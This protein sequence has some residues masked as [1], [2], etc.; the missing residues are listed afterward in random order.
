MWLV[1]DN[2]RIDTFNRS[3]VMLSTRI[4]RYDI[5]KRTVWIKGEKKSFDL[6]VNAIPPDDLFERCY[7]ELKFIGRSFYKLVSRPSTSSRSMS[8][9]STTPTT[10]PSPGWWSARNLPTTSRR[11]RWWGW[12]FPR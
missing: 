9:S 2:R 4:D 5:Q 12:K 6:I 7:G 3:K 8:T 10:K 11:R 1:D